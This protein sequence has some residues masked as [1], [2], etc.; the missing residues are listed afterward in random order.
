MSSIPPLPPGVL[1]EVIDATPKAKIVPARKFKTKVEPHMIPLAQ[2]L[3]QEMMPLKHIAG[4]LGVSP[5]TLTA[6]RTAG[7]T[8]GCPD[9][10]LVELA[11]AIA[12][13][14]AKMTESAISL[15][16]GHAVLDHRAA[17]E[18][19][20]AADPETWNPKTSVKIEAEISAK[21]A[22]DLSKLTVEQ[23]AELEHLE[24]LALPE[25][26]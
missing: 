5:A 11:L 21:P 6:W 3:A 4:Y 26:T 12:Q 10:L 13:G 1:P 25:G 16:K 23:L 20:K 2:K 19:L 7:E 22:R 15:L 8:E 9:P 24:R 14:R 17:L 18:L